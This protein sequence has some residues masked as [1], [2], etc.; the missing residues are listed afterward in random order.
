M[1]YQCP[2][3]GAAVAIPDR[4]ASVHCSYCDV[5]IR[6]EGQPA[7]SS[8][9]PGP[10]SSR[11]SKEDSP[12]LPPREATL[13]EREFGRF[14]V[15]I[16]R[17]AIHSA[18][19]EAMR[20]LP[21]DERRAG[22]FLLRVVEEE[23][24]DRRPA[25]EESVLAGLAAATEQS[26]RERADPGLAA[27]AALKALESSGAAGLL[28]AFVAVF[29]AEKSRVVTFNAGCKSSL[30]LCSIEEARQ[31]DVTRDG[32]LLKRLDLRG[33]QDAFANGRTLELAADDA[34]VV[35]SAGFVG[36][37]RGWAYG[38]RSAYQTLRKVWPGK[39]PAEL[40]IA[41]KDGFWADRERA[42][43]RAEP[44][45]GD[46]LVVAVNVRS[47]LE[48]TGDLAVEV[49]E[50]KSLETKRFDVALVAHKDAFVDLRALPE[51]KH[52]LV[53]LEGLSPEENAKR[54]A[55]FADAAF[56]VMNRVAGN[57]DRAMDGGRQGVA[58]ADLGETPARALVLYLDDVHGKLAFF[59]RGWGVGFGLMP[60]G[61]RGGN[62][63]Q[64]GEGGHAWPKPGGRLVLPGEL[65][66]DRT[67]KNLKDLAGAWSGGKASALYATCLDHE[68]D[69]SSA[70]FL[71]SLMR[72]AR[73]DAAEAPLGGLAAI[74]CKQVD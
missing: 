5:A 4:G 26:L 12:F 40:V 66:F 43:H 57:H 27:K 73:T 36:G 9:S 11:R 56:E 25:C 23:T 2:Q 6:V 18:P 48:L 51:S 64:F 61:E 74:T 13:T 16:L 30:V 49:P 33:K 52:V 46:L 24:R 67:I 71:G 38:Q 55:V 28:E 60:R 45:T 68:A 39:S 62:L 58:N 7:T 31:I 17:Q 65:P 72:A 34:V 42:S 21:L 10:T 29:D 22:L 69:A 8:P 35:T 63:Q 70:A 54:G 41:L 20:W 59:L 3:C 47:N 53:W 32:G 19:R 15:A 44:P 1:A 14:Q 50:T 37:G